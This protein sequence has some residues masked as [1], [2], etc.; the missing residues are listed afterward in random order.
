ML[1]PFSLAL[2][3]DTLYWS[4]WDGS[5]L[6]SCNKFT[7][8]DKKVILKEGGLKI[9]GITVYHPLLHSNVVDPCK[10]HQC[11]HMCLPKPIGNSSN[12]EYSCVCP[13]EMT[14]G[15]DGRTCNSN[16]TSALV[17]AVN[18]NMYKL[19]PHKLG[20]YHFELIGE[21]PGQVGSIAPDLATGNLFIASNSDTIVH[22][23]VEKKQ[24]RTVSN[25]HHISHVTYDYIN[26]N[27]YWIDVVRRSIMVQSPATK[28]TKA[29][30]ENLRNP[31]A[32]VF[33]GIRQELL[34]LDSSK[35]VSA[36]PDGTHMTVLSDNIPNTVRLL[37]YHQQNDTLLLADSTER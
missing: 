28:A 14:L 37:Y 4:D 20:N 15:M 9:M 18:N 16:T 13:Q 32:L 23:H 35:L 17:V 21:L 36:S 25:S 8:K 31:K 5:M 33:C 1:H 11:S 26:K 3:E 6:M 10:E 19:N 2:F 24:R 12:Y 30:I 7:G 29:L 27:I 22:Y 34:F